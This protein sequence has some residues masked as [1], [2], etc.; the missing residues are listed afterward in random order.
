MLLPD[1]SRGGTPI[2]RDDEDEGAANDVGGAMVP[3]SEWPL[4]TNDVTPELT[5]TVDDATASVVVT[6]GGADYSATNNGDNTWSVTVST[7]GEGIYDVSVTATKAL[8]PS[9]T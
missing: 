9:P 6:V 5:G 3:L 2:A 7:L 1:S 4:S 8:R